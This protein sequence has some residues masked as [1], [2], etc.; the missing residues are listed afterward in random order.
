MENTPPENPGENDTPEG[1]R[2]RGGRTPPERERE[3]QADR[4]REREQ[5]ERDLR[6]QQRVRE[7]LR[8]R[9]APPA[10]AA[11]RDTSIIP[12]AQPTAREAALVGAT[13][14]TG[15]G[16]A[17]VVAGVSQSLWNPGW[18]A[19][20]VSDKLLLG[21][22]TA[23]PMMLG[24]GVGYYVGSRLGYP[25]TGAVAGTALGGLGSLA[26]VGTP[27]LAPAAAALGV[28]ALGAGAVYLG[29]QRGKEIWNRT[30]TVPERFVA[31]PLTGLIRGFHPG[32]H[33]GIEYLGHVTS[34]PSKVVSGLFQGFY[35]PRYPHMGFWEKLG[36]FVPMTV[37]GAVYSGW[38][39]NWSEMT[40]AEKIGGAA[41]KLLSGLWQGFFDPEKTKGDGFVKRVAGWPGR[42]TRTVFG[43]WLNPW[44]WVEPY[45]SKKS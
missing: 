42:A 20:S 8:A 1:R 11:P 31:S 14:G 18:G 16:L 7:E 17:P 6:E 2:E 32:W 21:A 24:T 30:A 35:P 12:G 40:L 13:V 44:K 28:T 41:P 33:G 3:G 5:A 22:G 25:K 45:D 9:T 10:P 15:L 23:A 39:K 19:L 26:L 38:T 43:N 37:A 27:A 36:G 4:Q 34:V 29:A